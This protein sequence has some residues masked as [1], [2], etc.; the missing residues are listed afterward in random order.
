[1]KRAV[2][3][4]APKSWPQAL[5]TLILAALVTACAAT[6]AKPDASGKKAEPA[7]TAS[8]AASALYPSTYRVPQSVPTLIRNATVLTGTGTRLDDADV[9]IVDGKI[10]SVGSQLQAPP[11]S[12]IVDGKGRWVTPGLIDIHSHLGV[13]PSPEV[14]A[15]SDGK[16]DLDEFKKLFSVQPEPKGKKG[17]ELGPFDLEF[18]FKSL[19]ANSDKSLSAE[20]FKGIV[21]A[22]FPAPKK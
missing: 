13:Y 14:D 21:P 17:K 8:P 16:L 2:L 10:Q 3:S 7:T 4:L 20:E 11:Q 18:T 1:M 15:N 6:P 12:R 9:L 22:I 19:D 5:G